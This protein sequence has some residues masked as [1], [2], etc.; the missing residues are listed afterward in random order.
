[1]AYLTIQISAAGLSVAD[2]SSKLLDGDSTKA[3]E[4]VQQ[5]VD[6]LEGIEGGNYPSTITAVSSDVAGTV[7]GQTG[8]TSV[9]LNLA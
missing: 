7:S 6:L 4:V 5:I 3:R 1:M 2:M 9:S 8:G